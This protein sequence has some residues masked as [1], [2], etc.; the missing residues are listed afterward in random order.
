MSEEPRLIRRVINRTNGHISSTSNAV[1]LFVCVDVDTHASGNRLNR[2]WDRQYFDVLYD[3]KLTQ[4]GFEKFFP[5]AIFNCLFTVINA[6]TNET[7][8]HRG[9]WNSK[10]TYDRG[11]I[12]HI[13][14]LISGTWNETLNQRMHN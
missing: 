1:T 13:K 10:Q 14:S 5:T 7:I 3:G 12:L 4:A 9:N 6:D 11:D 8:C 2:N